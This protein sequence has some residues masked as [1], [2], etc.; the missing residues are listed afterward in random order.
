MFTPSYIALMIRKGT[1][2]KKNPNVELSSIVIYKVVSKTE[3]EN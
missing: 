3:N 1:A 2:E